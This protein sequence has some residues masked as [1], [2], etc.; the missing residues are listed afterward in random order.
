[1]HFPVPHLLCTFPFRISLSIYYKWSVIGAFCHLIEL[2]DINLLENLGFVVS[3]LQSVH[4][5]LSVI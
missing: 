4:T 3:T 1:M 2:T 5:K